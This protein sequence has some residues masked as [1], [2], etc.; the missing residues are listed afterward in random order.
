M[1]TPS[2]GLKG[3]PFLEL[4]PF[5]VTCSH[6]ATYCILF[7]HGDVI[8]R[9]CNQNRGQPPPELNYVLHVELIEVLH[10]MYLWLPNSSNYYSS[11][12]WQSLLCPVE[13]VS[14][15]LTVCLV[16]VAVKCLSLPSHWTLVFNTA[17]G[18]KAVRARQ[19]C[20]AAICAL[21]RCTCAMTATCYS[22]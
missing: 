17:Q 4:T 2:A 13:E 5:L 16:V 19:L 10:Y 3:G 8:N 12:V 14:S 9:L 20:Y 15:N 7:I 22:T 11:P 1:V 18:R 21:H 6:H